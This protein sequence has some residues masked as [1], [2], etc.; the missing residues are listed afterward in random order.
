VEKENNLF[1]FDASVVVELH[2]KLLEMLQVLFF[3]LWKRGRGGFGGGQ[4]LTAW[5]G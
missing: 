1:A 4:V 5:R 2:Q 3:A